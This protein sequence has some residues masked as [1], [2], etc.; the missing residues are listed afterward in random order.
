M[1]SPHPCK[2]LNTE[3]PFYQQA[4]SS[5]LQVSRKCKFDFVFKSC[6]L[7]ELLPFGSVF[8]FW[9]VIVI[10]CPRNSKAKKERSVQAHLHVL[11]CLLPS[12]HFRHPLHRLK[13]QTAN[14][15]LKIRRAARQ[16]TFMYFFAWNLFSTSDFSCSVAFYQWWKIRTAAQWHT[17]IYL[18][19]LALSSSSNSFCLTSS[20]HG[21]LQK[22]RIIRKHSIR[23]RWLQ[24]FRSA[25]FKYESQAAYV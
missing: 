11:L 14:K 16:H 15:S 7:D 23:N 21:N 22:R 8:I 19:A 4:S 25:R 10:M 2:R 13:L 6:S 17:F 5:S 18:S 1:H 24:M 3:S 20:S 9:S 12:F